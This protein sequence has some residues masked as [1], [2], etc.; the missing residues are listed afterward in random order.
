MIA[1]T[2]AGPNYFTPNHD[3]TS[4]EVFDNLG[5]AIEALLDRYKSNGRYPQPVVTLDGTTR[6]VLFPNVDED[7]YFD[8]YV[9][10]G[11]VTPD[12][13]HSDEDIEE[14]LTAVH[15][16]VWDWRL[17]LASDE[18]ADVFVKVVTG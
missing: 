7:T 12:S 11:D 15:G 5:D 9:L 18:T 4:I 1:A 16:G 8:C 6:S 14:V 17:V 2:F 13:I 3:E 10:S